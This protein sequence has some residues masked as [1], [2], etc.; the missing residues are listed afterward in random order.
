MSEREI[1]DGALE[2]HDPAER[3]AYL[4]RVC[5]GNAALRERVEALIRSHESV[6]R[7]LNVPAPEQ[8]TPR[9]ADSPTRTI[10]PASPELEADAEPEAGPDLSFLGRTLKPGG[11]RHAG[12]LRG[13]KPPRAGGVRT[14]VP[15]V[16]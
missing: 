5:G 3:H 15:G 16:R 13:A 10:D 14:G 4:Q 9:A 12:P 11:R 2:H 7:F 8:L 1:F 6:S